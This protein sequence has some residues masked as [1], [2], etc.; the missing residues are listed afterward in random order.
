MYT[1]QVMYSDVLTSLPVLCKL[2]QPAL[3]PPAVSI[4]FF[5]MSSS[6]EFSRNTTY[7]LTLCKSNLKKYLNLIVYV[8][9][10]LKERLLR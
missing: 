3:L 9:V 7:L 1:I 8:I 10:A 5:S 4:I 2:L 6:F